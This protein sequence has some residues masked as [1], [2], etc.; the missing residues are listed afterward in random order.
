MDRVNPVGLTIRHLLRFARSTTQRL[1]L[2]Y[3]VDWANIQNAVDTLRLVSRVEH[4]FRKSREALEHAIFKRPEYKAMLLQQH[5]LD[6]QEDLDQQ[7]N[8]QN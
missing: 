6:Q 2:D 4:E 1:N 3:P 5:T 7:K 8:R